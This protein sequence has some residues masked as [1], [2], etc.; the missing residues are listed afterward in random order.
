MKKIAIN[1]LIVSCQALEDEPL[2]GSETMAKMA[3]AAQMGG[4]SGIRAN[5]PQDINAIRQIVDLPII[6]IWKVESLDYEVYIT[7]TYR[8][9]KAVLEAGA[10]Y[11]ALDCTKQTRPEPL[12]DIFRKIRDEFPEK[13][14]VADVATKADVFEVIELEPNF[15][16]TTLSGYTKESKGRLRPDLELITELRGVTDIPIIAEG[17]ILNGAQAAKAISLG[18]YAIVIGGAITRPQNITDRIRLEM[19]EN[20]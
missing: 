19:I 5:S 11:V 13:G 1:S 8:H 14:I 4:A 17:N 6:G 7:P 3:L 12:K 9:A 2:H 10:D 15:I 16:A 20:L 18:A